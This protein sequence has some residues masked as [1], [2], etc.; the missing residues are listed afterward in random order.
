[1]RD[2][3]PSVDET[4]ERSIRNIHLAHRRSHRTPEEAT[5]PQIPHRKRHSHGRLWLWGAVV[6]L[7]CVAGCV[8]ISTVFAG[9][10][11]T[12]YPRVE[13]VSLPATLQAQLNAPVGVL[14]YQNLTI[15]KS[16]TQ[17]APA[18][19]TSHVERPASGIVTI[20]NSYSSASQRLIANT[21][22][23]APDGK[24]Y[25]IHDSVIVPG[26]TGT[27]PGNVSATLYADSPGPDYNKT[28]PVTFTI[29]GFK[30]DPR[31]TKFSAVSKGDIS[32]GFIGDEPSVAPADL[33]AAKSALQKQL[34]TDVRA[35][36]GTQIPDGFVAIPGTLVVTFGDIT[37]TPGSNN[38]AALTQS[39]TAM[40]AIIRQSDFAA[41]IAR[42][43]ISGYQGE[44][45]LFGD[46]S[47]MNASV[48]SSSNTQNGVI[49]INLA[50]TTQ[51]IWQFDPNA[52]KQAL[53]GK[54]KSAFETTIKSFEPAVAKA[55]ASIRP[56]WE[57]KFPA[58]P[59]KISIDVSLN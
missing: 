24:I 19:G 33:A 41:A 8:L 26:M 42:K 12:V 46:T 36:A 7:A 55:T 27:T 30:S 22:F 56:F 58:D 28:G 15:T 13:T 23:A 18:T 6:L 9:A 40:G 45:V 43:S 52:V 50:G 39:A 17:S 51:L 1:M 35:A 32:G 10:S 21:R 47:H 4:P 11:I 29:P 20:T 54:D 49:T 48:A 38:T 59:D 14:A 53:V 34:D 3:R 16:A 44:A 5:E 2:I 37:Q 31:Y 25:R 57:G